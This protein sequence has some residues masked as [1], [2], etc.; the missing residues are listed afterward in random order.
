LAERFSVE[1]PGAKV[2]FTWGYADQ[3]FIHQSIMSAS[4]EFI[5]KPFKPAELAYK[6]REVLDK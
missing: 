1:R 6:I 4:M 3:H 5:R 2:I